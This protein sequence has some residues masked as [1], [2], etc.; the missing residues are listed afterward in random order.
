MFRLLWLTAAAQIRHIAWELTYAPGVALKIRPRKK[1]EK[2]TA[3][4][5]FLVAFPL[6]ELPKE[7]R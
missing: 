4:E 3:Q 7:F 2:E 1:K 5:V 6:S